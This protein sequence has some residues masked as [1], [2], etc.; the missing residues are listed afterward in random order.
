MS[1]KNTGGSMEQVR[2]LLFGAQVKE[3]ESANKKLEDNLRREIE[4]LKASLKGGLSSLESYVQ[5][6]TSS[7]LEKINSENASLNNLIKN[8]QNKRAADFDIERKNTAELAEKLSNEIKSVHSALDQK[9][10]TLTTRF[11]NVEKDL[12]KLIMT[13]N[14]ELT[15][16]TEVKYK[17]LV[18]M[19]NEVA[20][21][22]RH[23]DV[24][25]TFIS[26]L[27][28]EMAM[29]LSDEGVNN[30]EEGGKGKKNE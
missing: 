27:F 4:S 17:T 24:S 16:L 14:S 20:T 2:D 9:I 29:K 26:N 19:L 21:Q 13:V 12:R 11:E 18:S 5:S 15:E 1:D 3:I 23:E 7:L 22:I 30:S 28:L 25:R 10:A 8:E 6:E